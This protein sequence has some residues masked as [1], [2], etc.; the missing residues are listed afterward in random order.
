MTLIPGTSGFNQTV[1]S[2]IVKKKGILRHLL[3]KLVEDYKT[4]K[5]YRFITSLYLAFGSVFDKAL[6]FYESIKVSK[7]IAFDPNAQG[8]WK[9]INSCRWLL[10][11]Q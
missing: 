2:F 1:D 4:K 10:D 9:E 11:V 8:I 3:N 6:S 5:I 7:I